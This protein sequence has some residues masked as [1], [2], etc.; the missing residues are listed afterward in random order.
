MK[1]SYSL[2]SHNAG[3]LST[4]SKEFYDR[5]AHSMVPQPSDHVLVRN[6][7]ERGGLGKLHSHW[8]EQIYIIEKRIADSPV[9]RA[10]PEVGRGKQRLLHRNLLFPC[11]V[12]PTPSSLKRVGDKTCQP[13]YAVPPNHVREDRESSDDEYTVSIPRAPSIGQRLHRDQ[14]D[15]DKGAERTLLLSLT[16]SAVITVSRLCARARVICFFFFKRQ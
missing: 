16:Q 15:D 3:K 11:D 14:E 7:S 13:T 10:R 2:E 9:Y 4:R 6:L 8:E 1:R 12:L 5:K